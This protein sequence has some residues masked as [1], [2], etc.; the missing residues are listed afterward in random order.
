MKISA[1]EALQ[2]YRYIFMSGEILAQYRHSI[3]RVYV[4]GLDRS[5]LEL[6]HTYS[7]MKGWEPTEIRKV[8][9]VYVFSIPVQQE[10]MGYYE[11]ADFLR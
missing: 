4:E 9:G 11:H 1:S 3:K 7:G 2:A 6:A 8:N 5:R 10:P